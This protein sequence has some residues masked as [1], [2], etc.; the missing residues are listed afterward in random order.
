MSASQRRKS[1]VIHDR[2]DDQR[3]R[4]VAYI[5]TR[6]ICLYAISKVFIITK[7][8][9]LQK[10]STYMGLVTI[11]IWYHYLKCFVPLSM[12]LWTPVYFRN[13]CRI[14]F[15]ES[16]RIPSSI[17]CAS[18]QLPSNRR[19]FSKYIWDARSG[20]IL[21]D[22]CNPTLDTFTWRISFWIGQ[23]LWTLYFVHNLPSLILRSRCWAIVKVTG[24]RR[25]MIKQWC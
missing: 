7:E 19:L 6:I 14:K 17:P 8:W 12:P 13:N 4:Q 1:S 9:Y 15:R 11:I 20:G 24:G 10:T 18:L 22:M 2:G 23:R 25:W 3:T 16:M 21:I 5:I